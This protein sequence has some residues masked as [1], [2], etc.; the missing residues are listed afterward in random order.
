MNTDEH[1]YEFRLFVFLSAFICI[2]NNQN[3][4]CSRRISLGSLWN[5]GV[6][7]GIGCG[8]HGGN[9]L[10]TKRGELIAVGSRDLTNE[11]VS[12]QQA[13]LSTDGRRTA[14]RLWGG[15]GRRGEQ[16]SLKIFVAKH[17]N[18]ELAA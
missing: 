2:A 1:R 10:A 4:V 6:H 8:E 11:V 3:L 18:G 16:Q 5:E 15:G 9:D 7:S 13:Q 17:V 14:A 12:A